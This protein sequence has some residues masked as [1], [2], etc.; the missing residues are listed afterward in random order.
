[1]LNTAHQINNNI[2]IIQIGGKLNH[3]TY[4]QFDNL[5]DNFKNQYP[6][7]IDCSNLEYLSS[8]GLQS[9]IILAKNL[10]DKNNH[11]VLCNLNPLVKDVI[12]IS[13]I[14]QFIKCTDSYDNAM[15]F[16]SHYVDN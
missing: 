8:V 14:D 7:I 5:I 12:R 6:I 13:G 4:N 16:L 3:D 10:E 9:L 1:M 11:L 15:S 2:N